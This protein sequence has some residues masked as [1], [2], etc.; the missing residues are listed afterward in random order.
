[1]LEIQQETAFI[2]WESWG[3][4]VMLT[5][6]QNLGDGIPLQMKIKG[7]NNPRK[8]N[9]TIDECAAK[10]KKEEARAGCRLRH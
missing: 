8:S 2:H 4:L 3:I 1:M 9:V 5:F 10:F 7:R 6:I